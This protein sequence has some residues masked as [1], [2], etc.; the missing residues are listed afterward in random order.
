MPGSVSNSS[1]SDEEVG[2]VT[3]EKG[4][5]WF[6]A[7]QPEAAKPSSLALVALQLIWTTAAAAIVVG[8]MITGYVLHLKVFDAGLTTVGVYGIVVVTITLLQYVFSSLNRWWL[9]PRKRRLA[10]KR[11]F[12]PVVGVQ[13]VGY[14]EEKHLWRAC[15]RSLRDLKYQRM[16]GPVV[17]ID[18]NESTADEDMVEG[19]REV[20]PKGRVLRLDMLS[21][22]LSDDQLFTFLRDEVGME[23]GPICIAQVHGGKREAMYTAF[24][25]LL[26]WNVNF[27][28]CTDSDTCSEPNTV[29]E[30]VMVAV[31]DSTG[32]VC[33]D[34]LIFNIEN[35][36]SF[37]SSLRYW[38]AFNVERSAQSL[39]GFVTCVSGPIGL[40]R[41]RDLRL[42]LNRWV[43]QTFL[44]SKATFGDDR[45]L[46]NLVISLGRRVHYTP[47]ARCYTDTPVPLV[48][49]I[50]QQLR[51]SQSFFREMLFNISWI[52]RGSIWLAIELAVQF[53]YPFFL[54]CTIIYSISFRSLDLLILV[55]AITAIMGALRSGWGLLN[56]R[57]LEFVY[58]SFYSFVYM[59]FLVPTKLFAIATLWSNDWGTSVRSAVVNRLSRAVH[60]LLWAVGIILAYLGVGL[61]LAIAKKSHLSWIVAGVALGE[62]GI[63]V[64]LI[65]V[66]CT[67]GQLVYLPR[68]AK[69]RNDLLQLEPHS[70]STS[71]TSQDV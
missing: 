13:V 4:P 5:T 24:R 2:G 28:Y 69:R 68:M 15:L 51:W 23:A 40:Y 11:C 27:I 42:V 44:G 37:L 14:R 22:T 61:W 39:W 32:A 31:D 65:L 29:D 56:T 48:R 8:S 50:A 33:G 53:A 57:R 59:L 18:G 55:P 60:A 49:F 3:V 12:Q 62:I 30:M 9:I 26:H 52:H 21:S 20:F 19:F 25:V 35:W 16:V 38:Y 1:S 45:H 58:Y 70:L 41:A 43:R 17:C 36:V 6:E 66:W 7:P 67:Y 54:A 10:T 46:T 47:F 64:F 71:A 34:V 63:A